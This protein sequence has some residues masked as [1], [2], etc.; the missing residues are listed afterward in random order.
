MDQNCA[1]VD[2]VHHVL[3]QGPA[4][5]KR[6][7]LLGK[8]ACSSVWCAGSVALAKLSV[9]VCACACLCACVRS[10]ARLFAL[11]CVSACACVRA[12]VHICVRV[13]VRVHKKLKKK[14]EKIL[15]VELFDT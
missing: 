11:L 15:S 6:A 2:Y 10:L 1:N 12:C 7:E 5:L 3:L 4:P 13:H 8:R 9:H 14:L